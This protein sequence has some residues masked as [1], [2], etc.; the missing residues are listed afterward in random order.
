MSV[1]DR[2]SCFL[3]KKPTLSNGV[4]IAPNAVVVGDVRLGEYSSVWYNAVLRGDI[5]YISI[6]KETNIQD[7]VIGHLADDHPLIVGS[8]V[9][10]GHGA[11]IHACTIEDECLIGMNATILDG[12]HI[13]KQSIVAAGS[14]V[15]A[16]T[17]IPDGS[18]FAGVPGELKKTLNE[19]QRSSLAGWAQKY[20]EV[21]KAHQSLE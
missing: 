14:L 5:N 20:L 15:P 16:G 11:V 4:F 2:L 8:Q 17:H 21:S 3:G 18:L 7:G 13:G 9:T 10:V 1:R 19:K 12:A 6:G